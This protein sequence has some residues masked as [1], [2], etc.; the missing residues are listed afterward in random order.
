MENNFHAE[1]KRYIDSK[2][3][4]NANRVIMCEIGRSLAKNKD[5]FREVVESSNIVVPKNANEIQLVDAFCENAPSNR[6]LLLGASFLINYNNKTV[7]FDGEGIVDDKAVK[8]TY[9]TMYEYFDSSKFEDTSYVV[10][11]DFYS[12]EGDEYSNAAAADPVSAIAM[13]LGAGANLGSKITES[14]MKK[15]YGVSDTLSK[16]QEAKSQVLKALIEKKTAE[17]KNKS[18]KSKKIIIGLSIFG[19][20]IVGGLIIYAI[21]RK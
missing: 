21:K 14:K 1:L 20:L 15:K 18:D 6:K 17:Q 16:Q 19:A 7:G 11:E 4:E 9:K 5:D 8:D 3:N 2:D 10:T 12:L 13:A